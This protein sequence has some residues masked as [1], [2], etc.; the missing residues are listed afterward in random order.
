MK[1]AAHRNG[2]LKFIASG[3]FNTLATYVLYLALLPFLPYRWAYTVSYAAGIVLAYLLYRYFVFGS[4][5]GRYGP[6][7]VAAIYLF[8]YLLGLSL[9]TLW[10]QVLDA[11]PLWAPAFAIA[12]STPLSYALNRWVFRRDKNNAALKM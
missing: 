7:W 11:P 8:Q 5:G 2:L 12:I 1:L 9:L 4:S 3:A 10:V 6:F